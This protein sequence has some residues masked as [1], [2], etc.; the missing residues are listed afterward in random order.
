MGGARQRQQR[1]RVEHR[2]RFFWGRGIADAVYGDQVSLFVYDGKTGANELTQSRSSGTIIEFPI[3]ADVDNDSSAPDIL[4]VSNDGSYPALQVF[5]R[6]GK[7]LDSDASHLESAR[8]QRVE[9]ARGQH[10]SGSHAEE[11]AAAQYVPNERGN[12]KRRNVR[13]A[14]SLRRAEAK[15][16]LSNNGRILMH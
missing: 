4:V 9:R 7:T 13:A 1:N 11:L 2:L 5:G 3:V 8:I 6:P 16:L 12:R 15:R 10:D 14:G